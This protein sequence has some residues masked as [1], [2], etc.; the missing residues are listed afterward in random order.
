MRFLILLLLLHTVTADKEISQPMLFIANLVLT[1]AL[2]GV[3]G[4]KIIDMCSKN[5]ES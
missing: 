3:Y 5:N 2:L 4:Y 1:S